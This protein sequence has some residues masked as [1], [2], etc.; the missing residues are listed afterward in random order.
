MSI[1]GQQ[2]HEHTT[3]YVKASLEGLLLRFINYMKA[4]GVGSEFRAFSFRD[5]FQH[6]VRQRGRP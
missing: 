2:Y 1:V 4:Q 5:T 6:L 3:N